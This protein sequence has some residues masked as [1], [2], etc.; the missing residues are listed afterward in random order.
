MWSYYGSKSKIINK[1]PEPIYDTLIEPF[2]GTARYA[3]KY[4]QKN[5][6]LYDLFPDIINIWKYL[7]NAK[8]EDIL[9]LPNVAYK[10]DI[11]KYTQLSETERLLIG[12]CINRGSA[13]RRNIAQKFNDWDKDKIRI[14]NDLY[15]IKHWKI[16]LGSYNEIENNDATWFIDP[17][18]QYGGDRYKFNNKNIDYAKL[19]EWCRER[20]GQVIVCENSKSDWMD[21]K[22]LI[23]LHGQRHETTEVI[24]C[25]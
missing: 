2:A 18:Y 15:K 16:V 13:T 7:Q 19:S 10:E 6:V 20:K 22:P 23:S 24:W 17:P 5:V 11:R 9:S 3:Y 4:W 21:F 12:Y 14:A 25:R 8:P 1:Y